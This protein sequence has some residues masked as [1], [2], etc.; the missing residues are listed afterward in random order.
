MS[1][2]VLTIYRHPY[3]HVHIINLQKDRQASESRL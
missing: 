3:F 2:Q 1:S